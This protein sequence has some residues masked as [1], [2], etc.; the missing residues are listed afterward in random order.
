VA[1]KT[2]GVK[3]AFTRA[4]Q[5]LRTGRSELTFF[6]FNHGHKTKWIAVALFVNLVQNKGLKNDISKPFYGTCPELLLFLPVK[7]GLKWMPSWNYL[8]QP[9][10]FSPLFYLNLRLK[11]FFI[12]ITK[13]STF[14]KQFQNDSSWHE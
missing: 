2:L 5:I 1:A 7:R 9:N 13:G 11:V 10:L 12:Q 4:G 6:H 3:N 8:G 14:Q